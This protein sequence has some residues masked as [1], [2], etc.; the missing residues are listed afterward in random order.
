[1]RELRWR[2]LLARHG[3]D[4]GEAPVAVVE[5]AAALLRIAIAGQRHTTADIK[6]SSLFLHLD[7][8]QERVFKRLRRHLRRGRVEYLPATVL[9]DLTKELAT[10][11]AASPPLLHDGAA[12][13]VVAQALDA[14]VG[15]VFIEH[16]RG[17]REV[18]GGDPVP[19]VPFP[20]GILGEVELAALLATLGQRTGAP[21]NRMTWDDRVAH[22]RIASPEVEHTRVRL[23]WSDPWLDPVRA[24]TSFAAI[25]TN[26]SIKPDFV[27]DEY[28]AGGRR[29]FYGVRASDP[30][31]QAERVA[32][33]IRRAREQ[34]ASIAVLPELALTPA[35]LTELHRKDV[36][37]GIGL[38]VAGSHHEEVAARQ[39]GANVAVVYANG[40]E[41]HRHHKF[42]DFHYGEQDG[43]RRHE[44]LRSS[45][46]TDGFDL[47]IGPRCTVVVLVCKDALDERVKNLVQF[48]APT[49]VLIPAMSPDTA[50]F[51][52]LAE[53]LA[54]DPQGFT[55]ISCIG[56]E[57]GAIF[58]RPARKRPSRSEPIQ[59]PSVVVFSLNGDAELFKILAEN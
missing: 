42:S 32:A 55:L 37:E 36:F 19:V 4:A 52:L 41:I 38:V 14:L 45:A 31:C 28:E 59:G 3:C 26:V 43:G 47:L 27:W 48:L 11:T 5:L 58:G 10:A 13:L 51:Q 23:I 29:L 50:D 44:H 16:F 12:A 33:G 46:D 39:P 40:Q 15:T 35:L 9:G 1:M 17:T 2:R 24:T 21:S 22:L 7:A 30:A 54:R 8:L 56:T 34:G 53:R 18:R 25:V 6:C 57:E 49:L 20:A